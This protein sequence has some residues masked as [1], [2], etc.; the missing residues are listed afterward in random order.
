[1]QNDFYDKIKFPPK[2]NE[3]EIMQWRLLDMK[4]CNN[5][6]NLFYPK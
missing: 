5:L 4:K 1:M 2:N 6:N 3:R